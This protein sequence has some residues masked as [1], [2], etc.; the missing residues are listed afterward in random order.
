MTKA[1][2]VAIAAIEV[3]G[4]STGTSSGVEVQ[5]DKDIIDEECDQ[6]DNQLEVINVSD[7]LNTAVD[8]DDD[9]SL[10]P[11][12]LCGNH[13]LDLV[14][15]CDSLKAR[16][17]RIHRR[18]YDRAMAKVQALSY[19]VNRNPKMNDNVD[20]I[21]GTTCLNPTRTRWSSTHY[22]VQ[23]VIN[24]G[25]EKVK[26]CQTELKQDL[27]TDADT[28]FLTSYV[29]FVKLIVVAMDLLQGET[30]SYLGNPVSTIMEVK[31]KIEKSTNI[32]V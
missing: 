28:Q 6:D 29:K 2:K 3:T 1:F 12:K 24:I 21:T 4:D 5:D 31:C 23:H 16:D 13:T 9:E 19:A 17:D 7:G 26:L 14:A 18:N 8:V 27:M 22:A 25:L 32:L 15:S 30:T 10:P 20:A 11:H